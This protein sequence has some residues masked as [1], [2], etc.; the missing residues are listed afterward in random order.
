MSYKAL[1]HKYKSLP[2]MYFLL[3]YFIFM[4]CI[5]IAMLL[6]PKPELHILINERHLAFLDTL[7]KYWTYLGDGLVLSVL[8]LGLLFVSMRH[9]ITG[10]SSFAFSGLA[11]QLLKRLIFTQSAR[12]TKYFELNYPAHELHL[13]SGVDMHSW[14]SFP[15]GHAASAF[16]V[17]FALALMS[18]SLSLQILYLVLATGVALSRV[19]LSQHFMMDVAAGSLLGILMGWLAWKWMSVYK[20]EWLGKTLPQISKK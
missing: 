8:I 12:P 1:I 4:L 19:Y 11:A 13:V 9:F 3:A 17:F 20:K 5:L 18:R 10:L 16:A 14:Y 7:M 15:S 6:F 2:A